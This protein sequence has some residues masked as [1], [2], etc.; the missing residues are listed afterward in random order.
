MEIQKYKDVLEANGNDLDNL[1]G[2]CFNYMSFEDVE[3][4]ADITSVG[5]I[6]LESPILMFDISGESI[7]ENALHIL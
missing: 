7:F 2:Q 4:L 1:R 3:D 5:G 6:V